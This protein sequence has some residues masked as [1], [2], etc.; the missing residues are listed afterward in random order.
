M[1]TIEIP[2]FTTGDAA[3]DQ[4]ASYA[5]HI[6]VLVENC[7]GATGAAASIDVL[8]AAARECLTQAAE[9]TEHPAPPE[10]FE[11]V[12]KELAAYNTEY[13]MTLTTGQRVELALERGFKHAGHVE[14]SEGGLPAL[15]FW[16]NSAYR[17]GLRKAKIEAKAL[18]RAGLDKE[19]DT[20][21]ARAA[22]AE[23]G[24][25]LPAVA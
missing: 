3:L 7:A 4:A 2:D 6:V 1:A 21:L 13:Y 16:L 12:R 24:D 14:W 11:R 9:N 23:E 22:E 18:R 8:T 19:A 5:A 10:R 17:R 20:L 25:A 15:V